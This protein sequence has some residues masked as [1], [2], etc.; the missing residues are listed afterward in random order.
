MKKILAFFISLIL[1]FILYLLLPRVC[2]WPGFYKNNNLLSENVSNSIKSLLLDS[3]KNRYNS[4]I[5]IINQ[6]FMDY[7]KKTNENE[8]YVEIQV[9]FPKHQGV[10]YTVQVIDDKYIVKDVGIDP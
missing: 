2:L 4:G 7:L 10:C 5:I 9:F 1:I 3:T 6:D 8:Y